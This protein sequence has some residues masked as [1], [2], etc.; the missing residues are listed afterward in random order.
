MVEPKRMPLGA[1]ADFSPDAAAS[2]LHLG[3]QSSATALT[4]VARGELVAGLTAAHAAAKAIQA[5][6][7]TLTGM[8]GTH[9]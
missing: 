9:G 1:N 7:D 5:A 2:A 4:L 8:V 6:I 3:W